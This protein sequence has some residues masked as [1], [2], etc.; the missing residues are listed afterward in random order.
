MAMFKPTVNEVAND[1][2]L[3]TVNAGIASVSVASAGA[4]TDFELKVRL[5]PQG[6][7]ELLDVSSRGTLPDGKIYNALGSCMQEQ[8][9]TWEAGEQNGRP[10]LEATIK[11]Q[12]KEASKGPNVT[13][14]EV[15][16]SGR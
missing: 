2:K 10:D 12:M 16:L 5:Q 3:G 14:A 8:L 1:I 9:E 6:K 4:I 11:L 7:A 15:I 13:R